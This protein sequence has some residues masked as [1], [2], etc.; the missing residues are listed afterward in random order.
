MHLSSLDLNAIYTGLPKGSI[1][2]LQLTQLSDC[3]STYI[4]NR[5]LRSSI[6]GLLAHYIVNLKRS[7]IIS[8]SH[9]APKMWN[10]LPNKVRESNSIDI[11]KRRVKTYFFKVAYEY[12]NSVWSCV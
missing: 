6:A 12:N 8:F 7:G 11:F 1:A 10:C 4:S 3:L 2:K 9:Y 5:T